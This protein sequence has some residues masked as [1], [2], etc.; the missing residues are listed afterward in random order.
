MNS[1][2]VVMYPVN[3]DALFP[4]GDTADFEDVFTEMIMSV[5][6]TTNAPNTVAAYRGSVLVE[7]HYHEAALM[8]LLHRKVCDDIRTF[9]MNYTAPT[10]MMPFD[11]AAEINDPSFCEDLTFSEDPNRGQN[12]TN[13]TGEPGAGTT[14]DLEFIAYIIA[15]LFG[16]PLVLLLGTRIA[17][18]TRASPNRD[19]DD[20]V[21]E[22]TDQDS[23]SSSS[24]PDSEA[25]E[26]GPQFG[27]PVPAS[28]GETFPLQPNVGG[29]LAYTPNA[30]QATSSFHTPMHYLQVSPP[31]AAHMSQHKTSAVYSPVK[32]L[33]VFPPGQPG[34]LS[35]PATTPVAKFAP[36]GGVASK[37]P[38]VSLRR[39][40]SSSH[41]PE[42]ASILH[43]VHQQG[44]FDSDLDPEL[45]VPVPLATVSEEHLTPASDAAKDRRISTNSTLPSGRDKGKAQSS[46]AVGAA[47][48]DH[49]R[50]KFEDNGEVMPT[51]QQRASRG[52]KGAAAVTAPL[53][54]PEASMLAADGDNF[55]GNPKTVRPVWGIRTS[56]AKAK[57]VDSPMRRQIVVQRAPTMA[58]QSIV[59]AVLAAGPQ[60]KDVCSSQ[61]YNSPRTA[62]S[63]AAAAANEN[64]ARPATIMVTPQQ[65]ASRSHIYSTPRGL[66][67]PDG[68]GI[69]SFVIQSQPEHRR[70]Y[71]T[72]S[73]GADNATLGGLI[74]GP[75]DQ[76]D[77]HAE[78]TASIDDLL[79]QTAILHSTIR[80]SVDE[81][82]FFDKLVQSAESLITTSQ[83]SLPGTVLGQHDADQ[84]TAV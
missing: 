58:N 1:S 44:Y 32:Y 47:P 51:I 17:A 64:T 80:S 37:T 3:Y 69:G 36:S 81:L 25:A 13:P 77:R 26:D 8:E 73:H 21:L 22:F 4:T 48:S 27:A 39:G 56:V 67:D 19:G 30:T 10:S 11:L 61:V 65:S 53:P 46:P 49:G 5:L 16:L 6:D 82:S 34:E 40:L 33:K 20:Y 50:A 75:H 43:A 41:A 45:A 55:E 57:S 12:L 66:A 62:W 2:V 63:V 68:G 7:V 70:W 29:S 52:K 24:T 14:N 31:V 84:E 83:L 78:D 18:R 79:S 54:P 9:D 28:Y 38:G 72:P 59:S 23:R 74:G 76:Q 60:P 35:P 15:I 42:V 71:S